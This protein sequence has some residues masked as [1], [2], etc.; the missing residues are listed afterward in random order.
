MNTTTESPVQARKVIGI[1][2]RVFGFCLLAA[3]MVTI[4]SLFCINDLLANATH[5][6]GQV[7]DLERGA[8][9]TLAPVIQFKTANGEVLQLKSY[10]STSP[11]PKVGDIVKV[12]YRTSN[13]RDWRIDDWLHLYFYPLMGS[14]F[15][16]AWAIALTITKLAG[17]HQIRKLERVRGSFAE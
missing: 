6:N 11:G 7:I 16:L 2:V 3:T 12:V 4:I 15:M 5:V 10:L 17:D 13:P 1:L 14:I 9:G 8:K